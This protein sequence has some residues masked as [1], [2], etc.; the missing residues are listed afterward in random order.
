MRY[1]RQSV[2]YLSFS[3]IRFSLSTDFEIKYKSAWRWSNSHYICTKQLH[4]NVCASQ[5]AQRKIWG[6][7]QCLFTYYARFGVAMMKIA[8]K[9]P[10][11]LKNTSKT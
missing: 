9:S 10:Y 3:Q 4:V 1:L 6:C 5:K 11:F 8:P 2:I 7:A